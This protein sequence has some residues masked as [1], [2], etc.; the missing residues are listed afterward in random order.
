MTRLFVAVGQIYSFFRRSFLLSRLPAI[1]S[2]AGRRNRDRT[3]DLCLVRAALFQLS[4]PPDFLKKLADA[5]KSTSPCQPY[6]AFFLQPAQNPSP[7]FSPRQLFLS[8]ISSTSAREIPV[9]DGLQPFAFYMRIDLCGGNV[10]VT[11]QGLHR[12]QIGAA[13]Q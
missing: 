12:S 9:V 4:Y 10:G 13:F 7:F 5:T 3:C 6:R 1:H 8:A 11:Q 2:N